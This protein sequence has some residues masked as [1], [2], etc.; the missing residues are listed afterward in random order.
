[1]SG[2]LS[3]IVNTDAGIETL[4]V[5]AGGQAMAREVLE[6]AWLA[7]VEGGDASADAAV[8]IVG[9]RLLGPGWRKANGGEAGV[10][11]AG[12]IGVD[13]CADGFPGYVAG[14]SLSVD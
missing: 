5:W 8:E 12:Q 9:L 6:S 1:M 13:F 11:A 2:Q 4:R 10:S 3:A 14:E 7:C